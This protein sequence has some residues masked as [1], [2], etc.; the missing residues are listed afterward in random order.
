MSSSPSQQTS[1]RRFRVRQFLRR[2][3]R[4]RR[5][6]AAAVVAAGPPAATAAARHAV[7]QITVEAPPA[8]LK[9]QFTLIKPTP[10]RPA[11]GIPPGDS[12]INCGMRVTPGYGAAVLPCRHGQMHYRC[13]RI[14]M[15]GVRSD[16]GFSCVTCGGGLDLAAS[17]EAPAMKA[18]AES[19]AG[20]GGSSAL[21]EG[22]VLDLK[23]DATRMRWDSEGDD[24]GC[25]V[26]VPRYA[27]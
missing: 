12:C 23:E 4:R 15:L 16:T 7:P 6:T 27:V 5:T 24:E 2:I 14:W 3:F 26:G 21:A 20:T 22:A 18:V 1:S 19:S 11:T 25:D 9:R 13:V 17:R 10:A 8:P